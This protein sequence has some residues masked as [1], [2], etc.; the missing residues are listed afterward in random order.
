MQQFAP[1]LIGTGLLTSVLWFGRGERRAP[2]E[3][4]GVRRP[5]A[6]NPMVFRK[7]A[8]PAGR[9]CTATGCTGFIRAGEE[10]QNCAFERDFNNTF[11]N[12]GSQEDE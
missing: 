6:H 12:T 3:F 4:G 2:R 7:V 5:A 10:C 9:A 8:K 11:P 1:L